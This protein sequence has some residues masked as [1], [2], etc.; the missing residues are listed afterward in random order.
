MSKISTSMTQ[1]HKKKSKLKK[2]ML[3]ALGEKKEVTTWKKQG[4][5]KKSTIIIK[6]IMTMAKFMMM[7]I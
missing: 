2:H 4:K 3:V 6:T 5:L 7:T 1:G